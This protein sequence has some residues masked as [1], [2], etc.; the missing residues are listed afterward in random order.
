MFWLGATPLFA[1][2]CQSARRRNSSVGYGSI[3]YFD[4]CW[5]SAR[6]SSGDR[7]TEGLGTADSQ[8][9]TVDNEYACSCILTR[10]Q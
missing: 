3:A 5:A 9:F 6:V 1:R 2:S 8:C 7:F 4:S 10:L